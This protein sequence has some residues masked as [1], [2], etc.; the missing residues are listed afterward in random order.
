MSDRAPLRWPQSFPTTQCSLA[1]VPGGIPNTPNGLASC[2]PG[3]TGCYTPAA[4]LG[5]AKTQADVSVHQPPRL[6]AVRRG[7]TMQLAAEA[8]GSACPATPAPQA[9]SANDARFGQQRGLMSDQA[10][11]DL[12]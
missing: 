9:N 6:R 7:H 1:L 5:L 3:P 2:E 10:P 8:S 4:A 11:S 12:P